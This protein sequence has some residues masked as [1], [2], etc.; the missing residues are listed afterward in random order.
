MMHRPNAVQPNAFHLVLATKVLLNEAKRPIHSSP[1]NA[2]SLSLVAD[3]LDILVTRELEAPSMMT[4]A[5]VIAALEVQAHQ[6][7]NAGLSKDAATFRAALKL[8]N[9]TTGDPQCVTP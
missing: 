4:R 8:I 1:H 7:E 3:W 6:S 5:E 9:P 2:G